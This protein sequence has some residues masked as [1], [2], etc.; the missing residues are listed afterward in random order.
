MRPFLERSL[1]SRSSS[2]WVP[3]LVLVV[4]S[5]F[6]LWVQAVDFQ[7]PMDHDLYTYAVIAHE[8]G[9]GRLLY[10]DLWDHKPP[11]IHATFRLAEEGV[12]YGRPEFFALGAGAALLGLLAVFLA[13]R[14]AAG[15]WAACLA[16]LFWTLFCGN[17]ALQA[18]Q[19]NVE[20]F[21]NP[22]VA[23]M[24]ALSLSPPWTGRKMLSFGL[25]GALAS[26]YKPQALF[27][28]L[29]LPT[30][31]LVLLPRA[32]KGPFL[33]KALGLM[34]LPTFVTWGTLLLY[35]GLTRPWIDVW[36]CLFAFNSFYAHDPLRNLLWGFWPPNLF[37][38]TLWPLA[39]WFLFLIAGLLA[40]RKKDPRSFGLGLAYTIAVFLAVASPGYFFPHYYQY[41]L[42]LLAVAGG[43]VVGSILKRMGPW[44]GIAAVLGLAFLGLSQGPF[45]GPSPNGPSKEDRLAAMADGLLGPSEGLYLFGGD[46]QVYFTCRRSPSSGILYPYPLFSGPQDMVLRLRHRM[47]DQLERTPPELIAIDPGYLSAYGPV[48]SRNYRVWERFPD[49]DGFLLVVRKGGALE[50][51]L[52]KTLGRMDP[53]RK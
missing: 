8:M 18:S 23:A 52:G 20:S 36:D 41:W 16:A 24:L 44:I 5:L 26:L 12:G 39:P 13:G 14:N 46:A 38:K 6:I 51:R 32:Q 27:W 43:G 10:S 1:S 9:N 28:T 4:L 17:G 15:P 48:F 33:G 19:P 11:A 50:R 47:M 7:K 42:P 34:V 53:K 3:A 31:D 30:V 40:S 35:F 49:P 29:L 25:L 37:P 45:Q 2:R 22:L 21:V